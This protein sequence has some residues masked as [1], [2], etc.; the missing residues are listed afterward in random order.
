MERKRGL[1][2]KDTGWIP[3]N[4]VGEERRSL[5]RRLFY[6]LRPADVIVL[7]VIPWF[8]DNHAQVKPWWSCAVIRRA[9]HSDDSWQRV[10]SAVGTPLST[11]Q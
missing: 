6:V 4:T 2:K 5:A 3:S 11:L 8:F 1:D 7:I 9:Y 10:G